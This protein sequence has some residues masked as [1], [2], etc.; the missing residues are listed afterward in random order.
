MA[1]DKGI[2]LFGSENEQQSASANGSSSITYEQSTN[3]IA[4]ITAGNISRDQIKDIF[5]TI[6]A[7]A[8]TLT[9]F[10]S[11]TNSAVLEI[12]N[13]MIYSNS[14]LE[15]ILKYTKSIYSEFSDKI[16]SVNKNLME[17]R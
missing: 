14:H 9:A 12:K 7:S 11:S 10:S 1:A 2:N 15:D 16:D 8:G 6:M 17:I 3:L 4:L 5:S 13:L